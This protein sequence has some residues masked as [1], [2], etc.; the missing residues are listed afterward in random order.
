MISQELFIVLVAGSYN[1]VNLLYLFVLK[2]TMKPVLTLASLF[3]I[4]LLFTCGC[5]QEPKCPYAAS[6]YLTSSELAWLSYLKYPNDH[7]IIFKNEVGDSDI[8]VTASSS[9]QNAPGPPDYPCDQ[10]CQEESSALNGVSAWALGFT[11]S[12]SH[13]YQSYPENLNSAAINCNGAAFQFSK[14]SPQNNVIINGT[15]Y[16]NVY[17]FTVTPSAQ[18]TNPTLTMVYYTQANGILQYNTSD[19]HTWFVK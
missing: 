13:Y 14:Y 19:G 2:S 16:N 18:N 12:V 6:P 1:S 4:G 11:I 9:S 7:K 8:Y 17:V 5:Q 3:I 10:G 15:A